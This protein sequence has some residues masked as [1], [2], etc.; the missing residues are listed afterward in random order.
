MEAR[1]ID[2]ASEATADAVLVRGRPRLGS[3]RETA[4][5][6]AMWLVA[7]VA[8]FAVLQVTGLQTRAEAEFGH[9]LR[10][11]WWYD[12]GWYWNIAHWGYRPLGPASYAFYPLWP[13]FLKAA[14]PGPEWI[15]AAVVAVVSSL[16]A[17]A[18]VAAAAPGS[19]A[20]RSALAMACFPGSFVLA[21]AYPDASALAASAWACVFASRGRALPAC[22]LAA[23]A[24]AARPNA[25]LIAIPLAGVAMRR[26]GRFWAVALAPV[27][28]TASVHLWFWWNSGVWN[29]F[30]RAQRGWGRTGPAAAAD[31]W[32]ANLTRL[33]HRHVSL[34]LLAL[35]AVALLTVLVLRLPR[36]HR[37]YPI[38]VAYL[39]AAAA[40]VLS[41]G[42]E[43]TRVQTALVLVTLPLCGML[44]FM[45]RRY[46]VWSV[47]A[48]SVVV[49]SLASGT[50]WS[51]GRHAMFAFPIFWAI[52]DGPRLLRGRPVLVAGFAANVAW[53]L[54]ALPRFPP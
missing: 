49:L 44:W 8:V 1:G 14:A 53:A 41:A 11:L 5:I 29:A 32:G 36:R 26:G 39:V 4:P 38:A 54:F 18:G 30:V 21:L 20:R 13:L 15:I 7:L 19:Y 12:Y 3:I 6:W 40:V 24:G 50:V 46:R 47:Y 2:T 48:S 35:T 43:H 45:G 23:A 52:A 34:L 22:L 25:F 27:V 37:A 9:F 31:R 16:L 28:T 10:P 17:F 42:S 51:F 33:A